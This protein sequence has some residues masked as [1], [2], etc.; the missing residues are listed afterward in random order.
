MPSIDTSNEIWR[1]KYDSTIRIRRTRRVDLTQNCEER[2][3]TLGVTRM[4]DGTRRNMQGIHIAHDSASYWKVGRQTGDWD[5][6]TMGHASE[7]EC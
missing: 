7:A 2:M 4:A 1:S 3:P 6:L 5:V